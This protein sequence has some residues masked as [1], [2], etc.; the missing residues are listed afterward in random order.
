MFRE[1]EVCHLVL[2]AGERS[3]TRWIF[4]L[5]VGGELDL[6]EGLRKKL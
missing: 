3:V 2:L 4:A 6:I 1:K 5:I